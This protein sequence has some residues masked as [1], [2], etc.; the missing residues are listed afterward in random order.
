MLLD[1]DG[2]LQAWD[3]HSTYFHIKRV[4]EGNQTSHNSKVVVRPLFMDRLP[5][6]AS[7]G[8]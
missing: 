3:I 7:F 5:N 8:S 2:H 1:R 4:T 6:S